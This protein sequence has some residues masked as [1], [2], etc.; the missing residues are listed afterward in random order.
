[1]S[2]VFLDDPTYLLIMSGYFYVLLNKE[3]DNL[4][5]CLTLNIMRS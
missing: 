3:I 2:E 1:M 5:D 4:L